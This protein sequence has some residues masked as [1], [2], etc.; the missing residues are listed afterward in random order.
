MRFLIVA[1]NQEHKPD[2]VVP[3]G[4]A[5]VAGAA[6]AAGHEVQ[7]F[8]ACFA[9]DR[10]PAELEAALLRFQPHAV[11]LSLRN[12]DDVAWPRA[13]AYLDH[14]RAVVRVIR[15]KAPAAELILGGSAFTLF[16]SDF[17]RDLSP[18]YGIAGEGE[19]E[20]QK[21][22]AD[23]DAGRNS[24]RLRHAIPV[25]SSGAAIEPALD[26]IDLD[27]YYRRGGALN[28]QTRRGCQFAC[29]YCTYPMLEGGVSRPR[30]VAR[31][32]D[33]IERLHVERG[34][35]HFFLVDNTFNVP[36][37]HALA[38]CHELE[39]RKLVLQWTAYVTPAG[40]TRE[41][42]DAMSKAGCTSVDLGTDAA[43]PATLAGL[44]KSFTCREIESACDW[45]REAKIRFS[46]SLI[47]GGPGESPQTL[48]ETVNFINATRPTAVIAMLG[49]RLYPNTALAAQ[50][51]REGLIREE[52]I[53]L[54][55]VFYISESVHDNLETFATGVRQS[56]P[57]WY[58]P[59]LEGDR[60]QRYW[61]R[62]RSHGVRG[63]LWALRQSTETIEEKP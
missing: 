49:V 7:L 60:W 6:R 43:T 45:L 11:G 24:P 39:R 44:R 36:A 32:V 4:A 63:P 23:L 14:Y 15:Q 26:L 28:V 27:Q 50:A 61:R 62:Q 30:D 22:L 13:T 47:L 12:V 9:A 35:A 5:F 25:A 41:V 31:V 16:A 2:P 3:L 53:G 8:D 56:H 51:A 33:G 17:M 55:P 18:D 42:V 58:F 37:S 46:H 59:G 38:F 19:H 52:E 20:I 34:T 54:E 29:S 21:L 57:H 40:L 48:R 1:A 10:W